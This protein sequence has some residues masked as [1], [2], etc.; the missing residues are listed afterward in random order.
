MANEIPL[1]AAEEAAEGALLYFIEPDFVDVSP[2]YRSLWGSSNLRGSSNL[3]R[4]QNQVQEIYDINGVML[5]RDFVSTTSNGLELRTRTAA[6]ALLTS[7]VVSVGINQPLNLDNRIKVAREHAAREGLQ[8]VEGSQSVVCYSYPKLGLLCRDDKTRRVIDLFDPTIL[9]VD[10]PL[11]QGRTE[12]LSVN[13][14]LSAAANLPKDDSKFDSSMREL[15][16]AR[17]K[18]LDSIEDGIK[19]LRESSR[20]TSRIRDD[21]DRPRQ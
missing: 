4:E 8:P 15:S 20:N 17:I 5:F 3:L 14:L 9:D 10:T 12:L 18:S 21:V 2:D 13:S 11:E 6:T 7:P 1:A 16:V 19:A